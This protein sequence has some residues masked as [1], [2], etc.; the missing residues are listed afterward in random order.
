MASHYDVLGVGPTAS[1]EEISKAYRARAQL[2]HPDHHATEPFEV[3]AAARAQFEL[4]SAAYQVLS[5]PDRRAAYDQ[6]HAAGA[7]PEDQ[8]TFDRLDPSEWL[9]RAVI[10]GVASRAGDSAEP[11]LL[12]M[13]ASQVF[14]DMVAARPLPDHAQSEDAAS[15]LAYESAKAGYDAALRGQAGHDASEVLLACAW[16]AWHVLYADLPPGVKAEKGRPPSEPGTLR[17]PVPGLA[18]AQPCKVCGKAPAHRMSFNYLKGRILWFSHGSISGFFCRDCG[19]ALGREAQAATMNQGWWGVISFVIT[20]FVLLGNAWAL[21]A[22]AKQESPHGFGPNLDPG[23]PVLRRPMWGFGAAIVVFS[24]GV[25]MV[26]NDSSTSKPTTSSYTSTNGGAGGAGGSSSASWAV[27]N[28]VAYGSGS[29]SFVRPVQCSAS[30]AGRIVAY[31]S[32]EMGCP[33][34]ADKVIDAEPGVWCVDTSR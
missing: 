9:A 22:A 17:G 26:V 8:A 13:V 24:I 16:A 32:T 18:G 11:D 12:R 3:Q 27:G 28:C 7:V 21:S 4:V 15:S 20:P 29:A 10:V 6:Q 1:Q 33:R 23:R 30:H 34:A 2:L 19:L 31:A 25:I 14:H 5:D